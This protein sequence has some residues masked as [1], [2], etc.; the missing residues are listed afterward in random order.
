MSWPHPP[1]SAFASPAAF[2]RMVQLMVQRAASIALDTAGSDRDF[3]HVQSARYDDNTQM[4]S[5]TGVVFDRTREETTKRMLGS[6][7]FADFTWPEPHQISVPALTV[8]ERHRLEQLLPTE[9]GTD[10]G[11]ILY[12]ELGYHMTKAR[13][14]RSGNLS[15]TPTTIANI[16]S[17]FGLLFD[18]RRLG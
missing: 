2:A 16:H 12:P 17:L 18:R 1:G 5:V 8:K 9:R 7:R 14:R 6:V 4:L 11:E 15:N 13:R 3:L 10:P